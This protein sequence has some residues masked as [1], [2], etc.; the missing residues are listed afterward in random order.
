M[1]ANAARE[2]SDTLLAFLSQHD[3]DRS[4][5]D[6]PR[7]HGLTPLMR[8]A[9]AGRVDLVD[10]LLRLGVDVRPRNDDGNTALWL[11]CVSDD[12]RVVLRLIESGVDIDNPN[13][14]GA[15][16]LMYTASSG[17]ADLLALLLEAGADPELR[18]QDDFKAVDLASTFACLKLLRPSTRA[19]VVASSPTEV[20][21][22]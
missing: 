17:K 2:L 9:L 4:S 7:A 5:L 22:P 8:A 11:A 3:F 16:A 18:N 1:T 12:A 13:D 20:S 21:E 19:P 10:E 6:L 15:T 14:T